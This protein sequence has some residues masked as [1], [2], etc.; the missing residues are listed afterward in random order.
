MP[1]IGT[2]FNTVWTGVNPFSSIVNHLDSENETSLSSN[3]GEY[4]GTHDL[5]TSRICLKP[6]PNAPQLNLL[7]SKFCKL[8]DAL[9]RSYVDGQGDLASMPITLIS[10]VVPQIMP[11][12]ILT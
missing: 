1:G 2:S 12:G 7:F 6:P 9:A 8:V 11:V 3:H 5:P 10:H 4:P